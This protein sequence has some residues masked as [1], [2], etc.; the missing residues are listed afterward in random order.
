LLL[1]DLIM[2]LERLPRL[3]VQVRQELVRPLLEKA[4]E[5]DYKPNRLI[6]E[7]V[8]DC[9][10]EMDYIDAAGAQ[11]LTGSRLNIVVTYRAVT[12]RSNQGVTFTPRSDFYG[13]SPETLV[14]MSRKRLKALAAKGL[15]KRLSGLVSTRFTPEAKMRAKQLDTAPNDF[16]NRCVESCFLAMD[17]ASDY[18]IAPVVEL[19]RQFKLKTQGGSEREGG[20]SGHKSM[21]TEAEELLIQCEILAK[22]FGVRFDRKLRNLVKLAYQDFR[23]KGLE[24]KPG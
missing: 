18:E 20:K 12:G 4:A 10:L 5:L 17:S 19:Y 7:C 16:V 2:P 24:A 15:P 8:R 9:L 3:P 21:E 11:E 1:F 23:A 14:A 6:S 22:S 13:K